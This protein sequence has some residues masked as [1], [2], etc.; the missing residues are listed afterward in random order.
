MSILKNL[1]KSK[2]NLLNVN[3]EEVEILTYIMCNR[4]DFETWFAQ[5]KATFP[6]IRFVF[7]F[8]TAI[9][10]YYD[11]FKLFTVYFKKD[12]NDHIVFDQFKITQLN[13]GSLKSYNW[14][15]F[16]DAFLSYLL[17]AQERNSDLQF[18]KL[19]ALHE[20]Q[21]LCNGEAT[22]K[23]SNGSSFF[24]NLSAATILPESSI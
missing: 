9:D 6:K 5:Q 22:P 13:I 21:A 23:S 4:I 14:T 1:L 11:A 18:K 15:P 19:H 20:Y 24:L 12:Q 3:K 8:P 2:S 7:Y 10:F 16:K 17:M